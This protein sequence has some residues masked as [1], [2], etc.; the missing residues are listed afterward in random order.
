M[1]GTADTNWT[2]ISS[3]GG[4]GDSGGGAGAQDSLYIPRIHDE[5]WYEW[6]YAGPIGL[7]KSNERVFDADGPFAHKNTWGWSVRT[8]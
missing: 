4:G 6:H 7:P 5:Q 2:A 1:N 8:Q 3:G